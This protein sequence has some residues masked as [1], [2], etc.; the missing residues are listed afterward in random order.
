MFINNLIY[1]ALV[2]KLY[3]VSELLFEDSSW[4]YCEE[5]LTETP[6]KNSK[7]SQ[8]KTLEENK[9]EENKF[10]LGMS[11]VTPATYKVLVDCGWTADQLPPLLQE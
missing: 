8:E 9:F 1:L 3:G 10:D 11:P 4:E 5:K 2:G 7:A 6:L